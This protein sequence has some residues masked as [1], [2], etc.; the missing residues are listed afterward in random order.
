MSAKDCVRDLVALA[1]VVSVTVDS[2]QPEV[3]MRTALERLLDVLQMDCGSVHVKA[4]ET[5]VLTAALNLSE[6]SLRDLASLSLADSRLAA[7]CFLQNKLLLLGMDQGDEYPASRARMKRENL[8]SMAASPIPGKD[9]PVGV[10]VMGSA[11]QLDYSEEQIL[12]QQ[13]VTNQIGVALEHA[14]LVERL[15]RQVEEVQDQ[16]VKRE[17]L[18]TLGQL[19]GSLGH[20]LRGPLVNLQ[21]ALS[22]LEQ[23]DDEMRAEVIARMGRELKRCN[24]VINDLLDYTRSR[25]PHRIDSS[26]AAILHQAARILE[27]E[28]GLE[29]ELRVAD[30]PRISVD[31][32]QVLRLFENVLANAGQS[33]GGRGRIRLELSQVGDSLEI[34]VED[35][36]PGVPESQRERIFEPLVTSRRGGTGLGLAVCRRTT[37]AHGGTIHVESSTDLGGAAFVIRFPAGDPS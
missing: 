3:V 4:G 33:V 21:M 23:A 6:E 8:R 19:A 36:G 30:V 16:L 14:R 37:D 18:A 34:R 13:A 12:L 11:S 35:S 27:G 28:P 2:Y 9:G 7:Q 17:R 22:L 10:L 29:V 15:E 24:S 1:T 31:P 25:E 20:E 5:L 32:D 26:L